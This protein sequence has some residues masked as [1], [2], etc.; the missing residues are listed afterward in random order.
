[1][2]WMGVRALPGGVTS[3][4]TSC[5]KKAISTSIQPERLGRRLVAS[6][7]AALWLHTL[8]RLLGGEIWG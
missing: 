5:E 4:P 6:S 2:G 1:M 7:K 3:G 8:S